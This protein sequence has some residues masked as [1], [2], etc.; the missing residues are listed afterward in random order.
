MKVTGS[1]HFKD[2]PFIRGT[3]Y[4]KQVYVKK[5]MNKARTL[6]QNSKWT[7]RYI[8]MEIQTLSS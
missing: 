7:R 3:L 2:R 4:R 1:N 6:G 5:E 8:V